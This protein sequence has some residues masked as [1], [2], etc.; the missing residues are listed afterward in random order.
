MT[1][2]STLLKTDLLYV[3]IIGQKNTIKVM[4]NRCLLNKYFNTPS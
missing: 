3:C 1:C 2:P 4:L